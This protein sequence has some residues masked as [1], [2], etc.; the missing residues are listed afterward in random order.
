MWSVWMVWLQ[1]GPIFP[2]GTQVAQDLK[3]FPGYAQDAWVG[4]R[5]QRQGH[6]HLY[7]HHV[8]SS[9]KTYTS[10]SGWDISAQDT[11]T[12]ASWDGFAGSDGRF[13]GGYLQ[14]GRLTLF[15]LSG[16]NRFLW[17]VILPVVAQSGELQVWAAPSQ[18]VITALLTES[19]IWLYGYSA[20]GEKRFSQVIDT[21][22]RPKRHLRVLSSGQDGFWLIWE[23][24][25]GQNWTLVAQRFSW[26]GQPLSLAQSLSTLPHTI[27]QANFTDD[28]YGG[29]FGIYESS[30]LQSAGKDLFLVRYNRHAQKVYEVPV[31]LEVGDQQNPRLYKRGTELLIVWEDSRAQDWD[32]YYQRV[33]IGSGK[34]LLKPEGAPLVVLPGPQHN[35]HL[36]LDYFQNEAVVVWEDFRHI[37][38]DIYYQRVS[39]SGEALWEFG[40]RPLVSNPH[41]QKHLI[42]YPQDFQY[43]W[44]AF[45]EDL[46]LQ[47][48]HP[49]LYY[50]KTDGT[51]YRQLMLRGANQ[52]QA[53]LRGLR[54]FPWGDQLLITWQDNRDFTQK[55][56][57][58]LQCLSPDGK[59]LW[60]AD[61][62]PLGLQS[63][64]EQRIT[65]IT[66][67]GDTAWLLWQAHESDVEDDLFA[68]AFLLSGEKL[69]PKEPVAVCIA[70]RVQSDA[71]WLKYRGALYATW[72]DSRS[73]EETGFDL[74]YR[75]VW[76]LYPEVGWRSTPTFQSNAYYFAIDSQRVHHLWSEAS[77][78]VYQ[79]FYGIGPLGQPG[80]PRPVRPTRKPQRF[81]AGLYAPDGTLYTA[82]CEEAPGPYE[83]AIPLIALSPDGKI[84]WAVE[85]ALPYP[86][87]LYPQL[88]WWGNGKVLLTALGS[89]RPGSWE[90]AYAVYDP[91]TGQKETGGTFLSPVPERTRWQSL[92]AGQT[93]WLLLQMPTGW[94]L[95]QGVPGQNLKPYPLPHPLA[96]AQ[97]ILW[98]GQPYL[99]YIDEQRRQIRWLALSPRP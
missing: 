45:L 27:H 4:Y 69:F 23:A 34:R 1:I 41:A 51:I 74:Y 14:V 31:C 56:Q 59:L 97:L 3:L 21:T 85:K 81:P 99:F 8:D 86:H 49:H 2:S 6:T 78:E 37:Q 24:Y 10:W 20:S 54:T 57:G 87:A 28:G 12:V 64:G 17:K 98:N 36:I 72:S 53:T 90:L 88:G 13:Y 60:P 82:F 42:A 83:Q 66:A 39:A 9:G 71:R 48:T 89:P 73:L 65:D 7:L 46:P 11:L 38:P 32:I 63:Q 18:G 68:Q 96:E 62:L 58:Y 40:G 61:G 75:S 50:V 92:I 33:E 95:Y 5:A 52:V 55:P 19:G 76:P 93:L 35:P 29:F 77:P 47:G 91:I 22:P 30:H 15:C 26:E 25:T 84:R 44:V 94:V 16:D 67:S 79:I 43:F 80:N 70:D